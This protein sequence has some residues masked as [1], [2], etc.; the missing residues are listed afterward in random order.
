MLEDVGEGLNAKL[1]AGCAIGG[2]RGGRKGDSLEGRVSLELTN[3]FLAASVSVED[4]TEESPEGVL[5]GKESSAAHRPVLLRLEKCLGDEFFKDLAD[6]LD[7]FLLQQN[8][9]VSKFLCL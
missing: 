9:L 3:D 8:Q 1:L 7:R 2:R 6:L 5:L 4:L